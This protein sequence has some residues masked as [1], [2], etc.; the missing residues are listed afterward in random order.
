M[1]SSS[2]NRSKSV[3]YFQAL[4]IRSSQVHGSLENRDSV[5]DNLKSAVQNMM[6]KLKAKGPS[7]KAVNK[8]G[9]ASMSK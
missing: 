8:V 2:S 5:S 6:S 1:S 3:N 9:I 7:N 4:K